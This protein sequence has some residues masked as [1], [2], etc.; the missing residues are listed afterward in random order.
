[1]SLVL[2]RTQNMRAN[3]RFDKNE[4]RG[5]R[6]GALNVFMTQ[7]E[8]PTG[9]ITPELKNKARISIGSTL[10]TP[11][12]DFDGNITIGN[13]RTLT[14]ADSEN[15]SR[16]LTITFATYAWGF[17]VVPAAFMNNEIAM[18]RDFETKMLKYIYKFAAT[19][20][21][22]GLAH[23]SANKT[24]QFNNQLLYT[25]N[26]NVL[27]AS[28]AQRESLFGDLDVLMQ[29]NDYYRGIDI[30]GDAGV[31][32]IYNKLQ[33]YGAANVL[34]KRNEFG[35]KN[36]YFTNNMTAV[37]GVYAQGYAVEQGN[38][39]ILTR[40]EREA[41]LRTRTNDGHE[42]D[43]V[44]LPVI[45][46]EVGTYFYD[47]VGNYNGIVGAATADLDRARK[48]H[49]GFAVDV[50]FVSAYNSA[51]ATRPN[52]I[53]SFQVLSANAAPGIVVYNVGN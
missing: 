9:I 6:Y 2:T 23:L 25:V 41:L 28:Y 38:L 47:S 50:A 39:G 45:D 33:Q 21:G 43:I 40:F 5:S 53:I 31:Q 20:D 48:Q 35:D 1:M 29:A 32:S 37:S 3:S 44:R 52:P 11:V 22:V 4:L 49:Y 42:W 17:T 36:V 13:T 30:V 18:Q 19:L 16:M 10:E 26:S 7:S 46:M 15:T 12:I 34:N 51:I 8:D 27:E 24:Q 14:I